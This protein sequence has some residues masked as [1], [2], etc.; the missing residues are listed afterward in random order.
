MRGVQLAIVGGGI[1]GLAAAYYAQER[2]VSGGEAAQIILLEREPR[3]GG[4]ITTERV[5]GFIIEGGPDTFIRTK[6]WGVELCRN[7]GMEGQLIP[8]NAHNRNVFVLW[9]GRLVPLPDGLAM[10]VPARVMPMIKTPLL[11][12][13]AKARMAL[14]LILPPRRSAEDESLAEFISRRLGPQVYERLIEPLMSGIYAG[15]GRR[16]SLQA[17]FP[18]LKEWEL[19]HRSLAL[20]AWRLRR[21][22]NGQRKPGPAPSIF[23]SPKAGMAQMVDSLLAQMQGVE[24]RPGTM[25]ERIE[26][27]ER[28]YRLVIRGEEALEAGAVI[29]ATPAY[30]AGHIL[31][32]LDPALARELQAIEYV[33]TATVSMAYSARDFPTNLVGHGYVI[34]RQEG[35]P[36]LACTWTHMKF[37]HRAPAQFALL[38]V[39]LGRA[40][41][42][43]SIPSE[44]DDLIELAKEEVRQT[45]GIHADPLFSRAFHWPRAMPQYNLGH[46]ARL[47]RIAEHLERHPGLY[48]AGAAY[49]G[50]G[51]PDC[52][53]SGQQAARAACAKLV[54]KAPAGESA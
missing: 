50:V 19:Q 36:A 44:A 1:A 15:D 8:A 7:L 11:S 14:D 40:G 27:S 25:V 49:R 20:A 54:G 35:R 26:K 34:P 43:Q 5:E 47:A 30:A 48:L 3:W 18:Y 51:V 10:M 38:R 37:P 16:L 6:P 46:P 9:Q 45:L 24:L 28:G 39:F 42:D 23:L 12:P 32:P 17:T 21:K 31:E 22:R 29:L 41:T 52:I 13:R 53:R 2:L 4:K 33:T